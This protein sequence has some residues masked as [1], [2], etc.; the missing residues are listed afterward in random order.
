MYILRL[1]DAAE[2]MNLPN[3]QR[4][5]LLLDRYKIKPIYGIIPN[6]MDE[7]LLKYDKIDNFWSEMN[8]WK[9]KGWIP[10][11]H[12]Y[13]H[14]FETNEGGINPV[15]NRSEFAGVP[16]E[17]QR[18]KI[19][20]GIRILSENGIKPKIF[21]A[22]AHTF[23]MNTLE[24][25][26]FESDIRI[27]SDTVAN[28]IYYENGFYFIPQQSGRC[29]KLPF[30]VTTFCYHPNIMEESDFIYLDFFLRR[31]GNYFI[32]KI[33]IK[34]RKFSVFDKLVKEFYFLRRKRECR[35]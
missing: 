31:Y 1:D 28:D 12:G 32:E 19:Q 8:R 27:I 33:D 29:R 4:M 13:T 17:I 16:L 10:A 14:V 34:K 11:L 2:N 18:D 22:P 30:N 26:K 25:L 6:N 24:A 9:D 35:F 7:D 20:N 23:D 21:F 5:E 15:N 3:W